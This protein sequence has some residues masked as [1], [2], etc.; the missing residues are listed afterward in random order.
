M[1][2]QIEHNNTIKKKLLNFFFKKGL[3]ALLLGLLLIVFSIISITANMSSQKKIREIQDVHVNLPF[4]MSRLYSDINLASTA[5]D[6]Y[7]TDGD[8]TF[9]NERKK[10]WKESIAP[11]S[12]SLIEIKAG[13]PQEDQ[14]LIEN[15]I[16]AL[17][18]YEIAQDEINLLWKESQQATNVVAKKAAE[19]LLNERRLTLTS[20][21]QKD[22][23]AILI[24]LQK[25]YQEKAST[26]LKIIDRRIHKSNWTIFLST[27]F[28][29][30]LITTLLLRQ[31]ELSRARQ[32]ADVANKAKSEFLAN[33]SHEIRTPLNG[34]IGF[35]DLLMQ[36]KLTET[37][38]QYMSTVSQSATTLLDIINDILDFSKIEAGKLDLSVGKVDLLELGNQVA[39]IIKYQA[40]KKDL[41]VLLN[42][43]TQIPRYIYT[44]ELRL[45][46]VLV[47]LLSNAVKFTENG[48]V[49]LK[50]ESITTPE[51]GVS[52][53]RFSVRDTGIGIDSKNTKKIFEA[54]SQE[55]GSTTK[56]FGGTGLGLTISNK[57]LSLMDSQL[58]LQSE[59]AVG[60][61]FYFDVNF[62]TFDGNYL[63]WENIK[64]IQK[65]LVVD[66]NTNN[67][68]ILR[69]MLALKNISCDEASSGAM[70][71]GKINE[72][73]KYDIVIMDYHMPEMDGIETIRKIREQLPKAADQPIMLLYSSSED[74]FINK[75]CNE[76]QVQQRLVKP[77]RIQELYKALNFEYDKQLSYTTIDVVTPLPKPIVTE[78][79][80][81]KILI[82]EDNSINMLLAKTIIQKVV[83][84]VTILEAHTGIEAIDLYKTENPDII[85]MDIQMPEM[86]GYDATKAIRDIRD[87]KNVP[88]IALTAGTIKGEKEK[89]IE[90]GM[91]DYL[92]KP[93]VKSDLVDVVKKWL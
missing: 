90:A 23:A 78:Q 2:K 6:N 57:L 62:K 40:H 8:T 25:K 58:H 43:S 3:I 39:D 59:L 11:L 89:C 24:P 18:D 76:L 22:A 47:N 73:I 41:E 37:Q 20:I 49:E 60:S 93:F 19:N 63:D 36:S 52:G 44:D 92:S 79:K 33:M 51:N 5:Q 75:V 91:N 83:S 85:F 29:L 7:F 42:I 30:V 88:I 81:L 66:D 9:E 80:K 64:N 45:K 26:E 53:F 67:R 12:K 17:E 27:F 1:S 4:Q 21:T 82:A 31:L 77:L 70:A 28:A 32:Q 35:T 50:I 71:L 61:L 54:F 13:V 72:G 16:S 14:Q 38:Q 74:N 55:D 84:N 69:E 46:Q 48:E 34:V 10:I 68:I 86:N 15:A 56:R 87:Q 65:V